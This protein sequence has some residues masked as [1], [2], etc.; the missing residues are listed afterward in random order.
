M[1]M[2]EVVPIALAIVSK[3]GVYVV[4]EGTESGKTQYD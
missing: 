1:H 3:G 2:P 4:G